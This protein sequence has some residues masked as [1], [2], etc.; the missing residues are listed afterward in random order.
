MSWKDVPADHAWLGVQLAAGPDQQLPR[1]PS[2]QKLRE[3][4]GLKIADEIQAILPSDCN[5]W[6]AL[7]QLC[8]HVQD[9][10]GD[11]RSRRE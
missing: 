3:E 10:F 8:K 6:G 1:P 5:D 9:E 11:T 4:A 7:E 2:T